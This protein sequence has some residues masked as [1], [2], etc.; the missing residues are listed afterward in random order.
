MSNWKESLQ[1]NRYVM[2]IFLLLSF[3]I[4]SAPQ[5]TYVINACDNESKFKNKRAPCLILRA[6]IT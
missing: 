4:I 2:D 6:G 5:A 3:M 1:K